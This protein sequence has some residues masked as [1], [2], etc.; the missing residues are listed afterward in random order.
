MSNTPTPEEQ[1]LKD[2][3][4]DPNEIVYVT[5]TRLYATAHGLAFQTKTE[6]FHR[7][8]NDLI[9]EIEEALPSN[10]NN[11]NYD[12]PNGDFDFDAHPLGN[13]YRSNLPDCER[14][15]NTALDQ[16]KQILANKIKKETE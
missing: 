11:D 13:I 5:Y 12:L 16:V 9:R 8:N 4:S 10:I 15:F 3:M 7:S 2:A 6:L 1:K 14:G